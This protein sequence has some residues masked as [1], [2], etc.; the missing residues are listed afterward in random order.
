MRQFE[1][2]LDIDLGNTSLKWRLLGS[3]KSSSIPPDVDAIGLL[4]ES[5]EGLS[6]V[7]LASVA[8]AGLTE[9]VISRLSERLGVVPEV[10]RVRRVCG[11]F[12]TA[13]ENVA[14][15]GVD[16]WLGALAAWSSVRG[17]CLVVDA[18]TAFTVDV[19]EAP[20]RHVGGYIV[21][22]YRQMLEALWRSTEAVKVRPASRV[23]VLEPALDT[24]LAVQRGV[25]QLYLGLIERVRSG[26]RDQGALVLSGGDA[27]LL[28]PHLEGALWRADLVL[29][30]LNIA[31]P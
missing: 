17:A 22:G 13:Y 1:T 10:C 9:N 31:C 19:V 8:N 15:L 29:D 7:R 24:E 21:P 2:T 18:G 5:C 6:R 12:E 27:N 30:G 11:E 20:G 26:M 4:A 23:G 14:C 25:I 16:R 28:R 3:G